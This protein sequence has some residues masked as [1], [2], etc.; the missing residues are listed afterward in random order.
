ML[1]HYLLAPLV[2]VDTVWK[3]LLQHNSLGLGSTPV[4]RTRT[5]EI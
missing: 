3:D 2:H 1:K 5:V 4:V